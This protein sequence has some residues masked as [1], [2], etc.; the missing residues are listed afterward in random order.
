MLWSFEDPPVAQKAQSRVA[1]QSAEAQAHLQK[2]RGAQ[3]SVLAEL[4]ARKVRVASTS[5]ILVNAIFVRVAPGE[6]AALKNIPG[7]KWIQYLPPAKPSLNAAVNLVGVTTAW[8][9]VVGG[10]ANAGAGVR[11]GI[12]DTGIDQN[13]PGFRDTGF[14][15]PAGFPTG[16]TGYTNYT[17]N[18]V[19]VAR[20]YVSMLVNPDPVFS[21]PDDLSPRDRQGH[22]T[23]IAMIAAG[24]QNAGPL[25]S[26][27]GVAPK[28]FLGNY[29]VFGSPGVNE[30]TYRSA[31]IQALTDAVADHMDIVTLSLAEGDPAFFGPL[32]TGVG[33]C[34]DPICDV[35]A[36][37]VENATS[38]GTLV[39]AAAGNGGNIGF[40]SVTH[41]AVNSPGTAPSALT[42]GASA[43]SHLVYQT[44]RVN[45]SSLGNLRGLMGDG[46]R[47]TS[48]LTAQVKDV[49][50]LGNDGLGCVALPAGSLTG[51][52]ALIQRGACYS[53]KINFAQAA[54]AIGVILYQAEGIDDVTIRL[55]V[56]DTGIPSAI[57][58]NGD[59][60]ALKTYLGTN[61]NATVTLDPPLTPRRTT[62]R[63]TRWPHTPDVGPAWA[64]SL[65]RAISHSSPNSWPPAPTSTPRP[66][67]STP[68][69]MPI[70]P[71]AIPR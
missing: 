43:N 53:N 64:I 23:A 61:P 12:I 35:G 18:K 41:D 25:A 44:V 45:D 7:V 9:A 38:L 58:G 70:T 55:S 68:M 54:G 32:D 5:Q 52:F 21:T 34:G 28:A 67:S 65:R 57:I 26:I 51:A 39:V 42:V 36:Q 10:S 37:A 46:P 62:R 33:V 11:I 27:T 8:N 71:A 69:Q 63:S 48:P 22:G 16:D 19:I 66:R 59:G 15:P 30:Y 56:Q 17:N 47:I 3:R 4:A 6:T 29:K 1:L 14:T 13:H 49:T 60:K 40:Q 20:S 31:W 50:K 2:V 24:V